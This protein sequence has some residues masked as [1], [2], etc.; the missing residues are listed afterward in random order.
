MEPCRRAVGALRDALRVAAFAAATTAT[1]VASDGAAEPLRMA[2]RAFGWAAEIEVRDLPPERAEAAI[3]AAFS[4]VEQSEREVAQLAARAPASGATS[5]APGLADLLARTQSICLWSRG[6]VSALGGAAAA[7]W[8]GASA[9]AAR[10]P[11]SEETEAAAAAA[12]C[13]RLAID[14]ERS[15]IRLAP[16][17]GLDLAPIAIGFALDRALARLAEAGSANHWAG[18]GNVQIG[19]GDGPGQRGWPVELPAFPGVDPPLGRIFLRD[20]ALAI[21]TSDDRPRI[22]G[23]ESI[24][25][26]LDLRTARPPAS[27]PLAVLTV[28]EDAID[29]QALGVAFFVLGAREGQLRLGAL[30]PRPAVLWLLGSGS[31]APVFSAVGWN[32]VPKR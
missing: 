16:G 30:A 31:G 20:R 7:I 25:T 32:T 21:L 27:P 22:V 9:R 19:R 13:E 29:A 4:E 11:T 17:S 6:A 15:T 3:R 12:Q 26:Y 2:S 8:G 5:V 28:A 18:I 10:L 14:R 1:A 23:G 24:S